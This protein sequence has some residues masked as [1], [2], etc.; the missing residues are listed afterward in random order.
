M[1]EQMTGCLHFSDISPVASGGDDGKMMPAEPQRPPAS[2][3]LW[4]MA[5]GGGLRIR[6]AAPDRVT[7]YAG[8]LQLS[9][10]EKEGSRTHFFKVVAGAVKRP[11][12]LREP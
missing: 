9:L 12:R 8:K 1:D 6:G 10:K 11:I 2:L 5:D 7:T 3:F 4:A